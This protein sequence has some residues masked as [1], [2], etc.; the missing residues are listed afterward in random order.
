MEGTLV[1]PQKIVLN[2]REYEILDIGEGECV[3]YLSDRLDIRLEDM[4]AARYLIVNIGSYWPTMSRCWE[5][6][7]MTYIAQDIHLLV[8]IYWLEA[9]ELRF[10]NLPTLLEVVVRKELSQRVTLCEWAT[11]QAHSG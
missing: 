2:N 3:L 1:K 5:G 8:D 10:S 9:L 11:T 4:S 7:S 6:E